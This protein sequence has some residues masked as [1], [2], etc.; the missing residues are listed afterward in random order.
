MPVAALTIAGFGV[1]TVAPAM[2]APTA[3]TKDSD[4]TKDRAS[5]SKKAA[6]PIRSST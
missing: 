1:T 3:A 4:R 2:A 6:Y 5:R